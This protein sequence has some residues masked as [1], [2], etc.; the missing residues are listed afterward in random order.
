MVLLHF[1]AF[2]CVNCL[3]VLGD[4]RRLERRFPDELVVVG[5]HSPKFP[6]EAGHEALVRAVARHRVAHPVLDDPELTTWGRYGIRARPSLVLVDPK[7]FVVGAVSGEGHGRQLEKVVA[8]VVDRSR[9]KRTLL[10]EPMGVER[11]MPPPGLLAYPGKVAVSDD[12]LRL[13]VADTA[14]DQVLVCSTDGLVLEAHT[15]FAEPQGV[16][17]DGDVVM[18]CDTGAGR[19]VRTDGVVV[20]DG[21]AGPWDL[22]RDGDGSLV[23]ADAGRHRLVRVRPGEQRVLLA[24]GTGEEG[25]E[26]GP[27]TRAL[28]AQPSGVAPTPGG[29]AFVDA[30]ASALRVLTK[31]GEV[32]TLVGEGPFDWGDE[33]GPPGQARLQHP[34]GV[35]A[36]PDGRLYVADTFNSLIRVWD[37][38][39]LQ[40]VAVEGLDEPGGMAVLADGRLLVADTNHHRVV[41]V[42]PVSDQLEPLPLDDSWLMA[43]DG[44]PLS[45]L[46]GGRFPVE[47]RFDLAD[48]ELDAS[49]GEPVHVS[50][51]S[52]PAELLAGGA[53]HF[54]LD[55]PEV[56]VDVPAGGR[57]QGLL[58]VEVWADTCR[59]GRRAKRVRRTRHRLEVS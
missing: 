10:D 17:F 19:V 1:W 30:E 59:G 20:A 39:T 58:L 26:D 47:V 57:G 5:V 22:V 37:G 34:L 4:L 9:S 56:D 50:V 41:V 25:M 45:A 35:V 8:E 40:T 49:V 42:D 11:V 51:Q 33:D 28:L 13:A 23:V 27:A 6:H 55:T 53:H 31:E 12:G 54:A 3:R 16:R 48:E 14:H 44:P 2:S 46:A 21:M 18:V 32:V 15:G 36:S 24:A 52:R 29:I 38:A 7:G 43:S